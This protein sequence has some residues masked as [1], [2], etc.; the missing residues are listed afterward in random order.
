MSEK[1]SWLGLSAMDDWRK[2]SGFSCSFIIF[3][4]L[5][6]AMVAVGGEALNGCPLE[7]MVPIYLIVAGSTSLALLIARLLLSHVLIPSMNIVGV[8]ATAEGEGNQ[9]KKSSTEGPAMQYAIKGLRTFDSLA[10]IFSTC[11][12]IAGSYYVYSTYTTVTHDDTSQPTYCDKTAYTFS[13]IVITIGYI[14]LGLSIIAALCA[15]FCRSGSEE[16]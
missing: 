7:H 6:T 4:A 5:N 16:Q 14:S 15:C 13:F 9:S 8:S 3:A 11:W 2:K 10:S 12:L 1:Q